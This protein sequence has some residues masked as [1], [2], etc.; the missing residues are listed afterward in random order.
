MAKLPRY[1]DVC[2]RATASLGCF[3]LEGAKMLK[4]DFKVRYG[5]E[6]I[7]IFIEMVEEQGRDYPFFD[8]R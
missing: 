3:C 8:A 2:P 4:R 6:D 7:V 1:Y 5:F